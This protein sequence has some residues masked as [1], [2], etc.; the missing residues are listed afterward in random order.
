MRKFVS[1]TVMTATMLFVSGAIA[2]A[3]VPD[4]TDLAKKTGKAVVNISTVKN[5]KQSQG[6]QE[7]FER[8]QGRGGPF[9][10]FFD[11]F[12]RFFGPNQ[13]P[14]RQQRSLGSGFI[15]SKD[16]YLVTNNH[17]V[18]K[19]EE[20]TVNL[21]DGEQSYQAEVVGRDPATDLAL[22]KIDVD[23]DLPTL[24]FGS[25]EQM[26]IGDWVLAIGNPFGLGHSVTAG[27]ISAQGRV[28][29]AG[30]Y[31]DFLQTDASINPGNSGGPLLNTKGEVI[32]I[33]T[34]I[35]AS[36]Q[37]IGFAIPAAMAEQVIA[38]L[39]KHQKVKRG[40]LGVTIQ[41]VDKN[42]AK[43]LGLD[44]AQGALIAGVREGDPAA[45]AGLQAGDV[46]VSV[47]GEK[48][49][50]ADTL[51]RRIGRM[52]PGAKITMSVWR[53]GEV[54]KL[55]V[56]LGERDTEQRQDR[57]QEKEGEDTSAQLGIV[58]RPLREQEARQLE[59]ES[60]Q[61]LLIQDVKQG[62]LAAEAG[63]RP[64]DVILSANGEGVETVGE[65]SALL[66]EDAAE[67]GAVMFQVHRKGQ[68]LFVS[69][70]LPDEDEAN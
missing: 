31:D 56:V 47:N 18:E 9:E 28:I 54:K 15:L 39:K 45:K 64:G 44:E 58:V 66:K 7:L 3:K 41:N 16:G 4:F 30:P 21:Q 53:Q 69:I 26:E 14:E 52:K 23:R 36:G 12:E 49:E 13:M 42:T 11:Q 61:G 6:A 57:L 48:V 27:I 10:D 19:A 8:F 65:L 60:A 43:A 46:V 38:Q 70:A 35:V 32:G 2:L 20:I 37:G 51:T 40:W 24:E 29:G 59:M 68:N 62:S 63:L 55:D 22:L 5:V 33:N 1:I 25:S 34:A 17:V 67:K 50:D